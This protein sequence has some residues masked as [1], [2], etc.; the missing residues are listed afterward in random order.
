[1]NDAKSCRAIAARMKIYYCRV[2]LLQGYFSCNKIKQ[3]I[4]FIAAYILFYFIVD[5]RTC[6]I[7][8]AIYF[9]AAFILFYCI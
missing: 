3:N 6:A 5:V 2:I 8:A 9:I 4:N 7:S 1:M